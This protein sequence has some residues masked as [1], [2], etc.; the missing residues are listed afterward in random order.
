MCFTVE[1]MAKLYS[2]RDRD[3]VNHRPRRHLRACLIRLVAKTGWRHCLVCLPYRVPLKMPIIL[4]NLRDRDADGNGPLLFCHHFS[5][6]SKVA[7]S[8]TQQRCS[9][10][11]RSIGKTKSTRTTKRGWGEKTIK[12]SSTPRTLEYA[13]RHPS[14]FPCI[15]FYKRDKSKKKTHKRP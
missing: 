11:K 7:W 10:P 15:I 8:K 2:A 4:T 1:C 6:T 3:A 5:T 13:F 9:R 12:V 14:L